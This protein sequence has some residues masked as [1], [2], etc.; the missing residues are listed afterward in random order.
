MKTNEGDIDMGSNLKKTKLIRSRKAKPNKANQ[1][2]N[3][4]RIQK[5]QEILKELASK[6]KA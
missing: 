5:N 4:K 1:K 3:M 6:D 2:A